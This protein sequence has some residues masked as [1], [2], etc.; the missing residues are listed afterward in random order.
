MSWVFS[1][2]AFWAALDRQVLA[3]FRPTV[4]PVRSV[5]LESA[6]SLLVDNR[7][8]YARILLILINIILSDSNEITGSSRLCYTPSVCS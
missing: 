2:G 3:R 5:P 6:I 4:N 7:N 1:Q 8:A